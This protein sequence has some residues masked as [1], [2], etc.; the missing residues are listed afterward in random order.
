MRRRVKSF[1]WIVI[2]ARFGAI[3]C[4]DEA[5]EF[6]GTIPDDTVVVKNCW[7]EFVDIKEGVYKSRPQNKFR[8]IRVYSP[9][10]AD[11]A[12]RVS[13]ARKNLLVE[14]GICSQMEACAMVTAYDA[15]TLMDT[16][17]QLLEDDTT[18]ATFREKVEKLH[19]N[20]HHTVVF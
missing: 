11:E 19:T 9:T 10:K 7:V 13:S 18:H 17:K 2:G 4:E 15:D 5:V 1:A 6:V 20:E 16:L 14:A 3:R 8:T 12:R